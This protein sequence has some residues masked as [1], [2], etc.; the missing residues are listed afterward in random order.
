MAGIKEADF[1]ADLEKILGSGLNK[2]G[3]KSNYFL[4]LGFLLFLIVLSWSIIIFL[5]ASYINYFNKY[6]KV[7]NNLNFQLKGDISR[8]NKIKTNLVFFRNV[9]KNQVNVSYLLY[10]LSVRRFGDTAIKSMSVNKGRVNISIFSLEKSFAKNLNL[11][12]DYALYLNIYGLNT[13]TGRFAISSFNGNNSIKNA[14]TLWGLSSGRF[15]V[16]SDY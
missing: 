5:Y 9:A 8:F 11:M 3:F 10:L 16:N 12:N 15:N 1:H 14:Q 13:H 7:L 6:D 4:K 2:N